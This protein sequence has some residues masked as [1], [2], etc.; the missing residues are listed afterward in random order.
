LKLG[1]W[2]QVF[3]RVARNVVMG[4]IEGYN[5]TIFAYGQ[6]RSAADSSGFAAAAAA[7]AANQ[8]IDAAV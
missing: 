5:G 2:L 4:S 3:E 8:V 7:A 1:V 6:V